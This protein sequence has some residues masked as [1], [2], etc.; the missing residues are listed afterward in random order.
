MF[1][2][3]LILIHFESTLRFNRWLHR[4]ENTIGIKNFIPKKM[5]GDTV[6]KVFAFGFSWMFRSV[7][8]IFEF[9]FYMIIFYWIPLRIINKPLHFQDLNLAYFHSYMI[10][11]FIVVSCILSPICFNHFLPDDAYEGMYLLESF[12]MEARRMATLLYVKE[13]IKTSLGLVACLLFFVA[14]NCITL[15]EVFI[16]MFLRGSFCWFFSQINIIYYV[17]KLFFHRHYFHFI[18]SLV[19]GGLILIALFFQVHIEIPLYGCFIA[20]CIVLYFSY[21]LYNNKFKTCDLYAIMRHACQIQVGVWEDAQK[22]VNKKSIVIDTTVQ[23]DD[24]RSGDTGFGLF[25]KLFFMRHRRHLRKPIYRISCM[26]ALVFIV[27]G[28]V[29]TTIPELKAEI[30][31]L[32]DQGLAYFLYAAYYVN[33]GARLCAAM[34]FNCDSSMLTYRFY[35]KPEYLLNNFLLRLKTLVLY[36]LVPGSIMAFGVVFIMVLSNYEASFLLYLATFVAVLLM[37]LIFCIHSLVLY[38]LL[39]P[40]NIEMQ[41]KGIGYRVANIFTFTITWFLIV[42]GVSISLLVSSLILFFIA[43]LCI[44]SVLIYRLAPKT[45]KLHR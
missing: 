4:L 40:Y 9:L 6:V 19:L 23:K 32:M 45:F 37:N 21:W 3:M 27:F 18:I 13:A 38:Y 36:H 7:K 24:K 2:D 39:Q 28:I 41:E 43:Y 35:R 30:H 31:V 8:I 12:R 10:L 44:G 42:G 26:I 22:S 25:N 11:I 20:A 1:K 16:L 5:R 17:Q 33:R 14:F 15:L 29:I 34:F